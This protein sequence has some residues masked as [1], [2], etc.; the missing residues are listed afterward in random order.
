VEREALLSGSVQPGGREPAPPPLDLVQAFVNTVDR[1]HGPDLLDD[2]GDARAWAQRRGLV[3]ARDELGRAREVREALRALL[4]DPGDARAVAAL[5]AAATGLRPRFAPARL[6][7]PRAGD[8]VAA[9]L[10]ATHAAMATGT[11]SRLK[12]CPGPR[13]AWAFYDRSPNRSAT[14]CSMQVCGGRAKAGTY[15]RRRGRHA[16]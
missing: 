4:L 7:A 1:E 9:V 3:L 2:P 16:R 6:E 8:A 13:C 11:W 10:A 14:W 12:A 15:Y 5:D